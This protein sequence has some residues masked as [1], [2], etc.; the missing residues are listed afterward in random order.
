MESSSLSAAAVPLSASDD[1]AAPPIHPKA[2]PTVVGLVVLVL[3]LVLV[4]E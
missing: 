1:G 4:R 2:D 3:V